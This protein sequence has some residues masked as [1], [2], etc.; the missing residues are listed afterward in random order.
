MKPLYL[1]L[2]LTFLLSMKLSAQA[3]SSFKFQGVARDASGTIYSSQAIQVRFLILEEDGSVNPPLIYEEQ[4]TIFTSPQGVFSVNVGEGTVIQGDFS[5]LD[6]ANEQYSLQVKLDANGSNNFIDLGKSRLLSVPY[7]LHAETVSNADDADADPTNEIQSL[8]LSGTDLSISGVATPVD[9][10]GLGGSLSLPY[11]GETSVNKA[12]FHVQNNFPNGRYGLAGTVGAVELPNNNA[13]LIGMGNAASGVLG[14]STNSFLSGVFGISESATGYG[15]TGVNDAGGIGALFRTTPNGRA[16]LVTTTG[17]VGLGTES[18]LDKVEIVDNKKTRLSLNGE[19]S[20]GISSLAFRQ[21][22]GIDSYRGWLWEADLS[23]LEEIKLGLYDYNFLVGNADFENKMPAYELSTR[24]VQG[25]RMFTHRWTGNAQMDNSLT[26]E[27]RDAGFS[28]LSFFPAAEGNVAK[29]MRYSATYDPSTQI[30]ELSLAQVDYDT[31]NAPIFFLPNQLHTAKVFPSG[32][33]EHRFTGRMKISGEDNAS[34]SGASLS[35]ELNTENADH[36]ITLETSKDGDGDAQFSMQELFIAD[37]GGGASLNPLYTVISNQVNSPSGLGGMHWFYGGIQAAGLSI[38][39]AAFSKTPL[40][41]GSKLYVSLS[42]DSPQSGLH[43]DNDAVNTPAAQLHNDSGLALE[44]LGGIDVRLNSNLSKP[45]LRLTEDQD[46]YSRLEFN[47]TQNNNF[48]HIAGQAAEEPANSRMNI[49]FRDGNV[50]RDILTVRGNGNVGVNTF[51]PSARLT[52]NQASQQVG[53]GLRFVDG[54]ANQDWDITHG[55]GLRFHYGGSLRAAISATNGA[56]IQGSDARLKK[57]VVQLEPVLTKVAKLRPTSYQY[58]SDQ[59]QSRTFGFIAQEV[60]KVFPELVEYIPS[61]DLYGIN[62][63]GFGVVAI[64][65]IQEL[66]TVLKQQDA[67]ISELTAELQN[68]EKQSRSTDSTRQLLE[69]QQQ[70][71]QKLEDK[72]ARQEDRLNRLERMLKEK[73]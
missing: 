61:D 49:F 70:Y 45:Q 13:G 8:N 23:D 11:F 50:G 42:E 69:T 6:W 4:H 34:T 3:P 27:G 32:I 59:S 39:D 52:I 54:T 28:S 24:A 67:S 2:L 55:F 19:N 35:L 20:N 18:P 31:A 68:I 71:I 36:G 64:Q 9:L 37:N 14:I 40:D 65:A 53:T 73:E 48:W 22:E 17:R 15:V 62:Y 58:R 57:N 60:Q 72:L 12:A 26:I 51:S 21:F 1:F 63:S 46:D 44:T 43:I 7:A 10:S 47:N 5:V 30:T 41:P 25:N 29:T 16:A 33:S 56:Y 38:A 66:Q